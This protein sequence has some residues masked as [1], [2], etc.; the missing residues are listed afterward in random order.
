MKLP[1]AKLRADSRWPEYAR[2]WLATIGTPAPF[3]I[4][5]PDSIPMVEFASDAVARATHGMEI[6]AGR[7][8][9]A[10]A[11]A[12]A[13]QSEAARATAQTAEMVAGV[14]VGAPAERAPDPAPASVGT[15]AGP[16]PR[17]RR[18]GSFDRLG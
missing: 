6:H 12:S 5:T 4:F 9:D 8:R 11:Q 18:P 3:M 7:A 17:A 16:A 15:G 13:W 2:E 14:P 10:R 1:D